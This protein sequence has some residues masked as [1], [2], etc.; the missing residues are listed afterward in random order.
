MAAE[1]S[2][3]RV[4]VADDEHLM[5]SGVC[6]LLRS[7]GYEPIGPYADGRT[8]LEAA[9]RHPPDMMLLDIR[10]PDMDGVEVAQRGWAEAGVP[11]VLL[12]AYS[13]QQSV[14][15]SLDAGVFGYLLKPM[16]PDSLRVALSVALARAAEAV[17]DRTRAA[18]L[19]RL[20]NERKAV[21]AAKWRLVSEANLTEPEA[22]RALQQWARNHREKLGDVAERVS[23][24]NYLDIVSEFRSA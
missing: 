19:E 4:L 9:L 23:K 18:K 3:A 24:G 21:E 15:R 22:H 20:L 6:S 12:T 5:A 10:M 2:T 16:S 17:A 8:A 7:L 14:S 11:T 1:S 13:D